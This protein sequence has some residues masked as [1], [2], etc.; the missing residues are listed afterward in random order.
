MADWGVGLKPTVMPDLFRHPPGL[1]RIAKLG[2][3]C[4]DQEW[5]PEQV[6]GDVE[7]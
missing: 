3:L 5:T 6:Q 1:A 2:T 4:Q 7:A